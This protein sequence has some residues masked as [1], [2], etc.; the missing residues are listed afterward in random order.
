MENNNDDDGNQNKKAN[1]SKRNKTYFF[2]GS[3]HPLRI[4]SLGITDHE[5]L[6]RDLRCKKRCKTVPLLKRGRDETMLNRNLCE[7]VIATYSPNL[8]LTYATP[9][10][11]VI[12]NKIPSLGV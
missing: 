9:S 10:G 3:K 12:H 11:C 1:K 7:A 6:K 2:L 4:N 5:L 8:M